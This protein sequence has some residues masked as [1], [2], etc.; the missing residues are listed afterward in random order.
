MKKNINFSGLGIEIGQSLSGLNRSSLEVPHFQKI[1]NELDFTF[2]YKGHINQVNDLRPIKV[3]SEFDLNKILL[4]E[5]V[6]SYFKTINL[7]KEDVPLVNWGGDHSI[8]ISTVSAFLNQY[9]HGYVVWIDAHGDINIPSRSLTG[10]FHGM[11]L[12]VL[13][14]LENIGVN[15]FH[16]IDSFLK[17]DK[18]IYL[19]LRDLDPFEKELIFNKNINSFTFREIYFDGIKNVLDKILKIVGSSPVHISFDIDSTDPLFASST[20]VPV[21]GG[22][23]PSDLE[24]IGNIFNKNLNIKSIDVVEIN[25]TIGTAQEVEQT[26]LTAFKF[27][28]SIFSNK[29]LG[30]NDENMGNRIQAECYDEMEWSS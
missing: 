21:M 3:R 4:D 19:G 18:L 10:S 9:P 1:L 23:T 29:I 12:A 8:A 22:F 16:W 15:Y 13:L 25:P 28:N 2:N 6:Q 5:Y 14:N 26:Y 30:V 7:L 27:L 11:P 20:G 17:S 24:I